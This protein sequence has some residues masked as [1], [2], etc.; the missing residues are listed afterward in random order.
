MDKDFDM[1]DIKSAWLESWVY[2]FESLTF[3]V[4]WS[5]VNEVE[6]VVS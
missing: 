3:W 4:K 5:K 2:D 6:V 1:L